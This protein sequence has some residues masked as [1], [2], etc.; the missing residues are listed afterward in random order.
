[1]R[2]SNWKCVKIVFG[3]GFFPNPT[4]GANSAPPDLLAA[5]R[6]PALIVRK[7]SIGEKRQN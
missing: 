4:G 2:L 7:G 6:G 1:M 5:L 3:R